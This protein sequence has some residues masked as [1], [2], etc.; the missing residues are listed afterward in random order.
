MTCAARNAFAFV[1]ILLALLSL[2]DDAEA[3]PKLWINYED[4]YSLTD[5]STVIGIWFDDRNQRAAVESTDWDGRRFVADASMIK[6][7]RR[8]VQLDRDH[9]I[10]VQRSEAPGGNP[11]D[12]PKEIEA[13][14]RLQRI[15]RAV[16]VTAIDAPG[17]AAEVIYLETRGRAVGRIVDPDEKAR[18][19]KT[20]EAGWPQ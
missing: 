7:V 6:K 15:T 3:Q 19:K 10:R 9:W 8:I 13:Y 2:S 17:G 14:A 11:W 20:L 1:F 12:D 5:W 16:V 4:G 18:F